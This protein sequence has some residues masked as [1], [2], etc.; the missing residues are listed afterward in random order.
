MCKERKGEIKGG[1]GEG[2]TWYIDVRRRMRDDKEGYHVT[3]FGKLEVGLASAM[4]C[5]SSSGVQ[6]TCSNM[7]NHKERYHV[8]CFKKLEGGLVSAMAC[9]SS[10]EMLQDEMRERAV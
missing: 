6:E 5:V 10:S 1:T 2:K 3:C 7:R 8:T 9:F 4:T